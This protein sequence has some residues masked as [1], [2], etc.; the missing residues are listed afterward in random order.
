MKRRVLGIVLALILATVGTLALVAYVKSAKKDASKN[1]EQVKVYVVTKDIRLGATVSE[2]KQQITLTD[3]PK[4]LE[5]TG[6]VT[7]LTQLKDTL[8]AGVRLKAG[9]QLLSSRL[10]DPLTLV[11]VAVPNG[12]QEMT[13]ALSP[14]RA[15]G[16]ALSPGDTVGIVISY[17]SGSISSTGP[18]TE[19]TT[20]L[21][22]GADTTSS[23]TPR[24]LSTTHLTLQKIL[25]TAVQLSQQD[26]QRASK[27]NVAAPSGAGPADTIA[28]NVNEAPSGQ[29]LITLAVSGPQVEQIVF[30]AEFGHIWL[31]LEGANADEGGTRIL[32][33]DQ[34]YVTVGKR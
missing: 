3:V 23:T 10:V 12:L 13:V 26:S 19:S 2:I 30:A 20:T 15:V 17:D 16:A 11:R 8:V 33:L 14:E 25:V 34:A 28:A 29:L 22:G 4:R 32:T 21:A 1:E 24:S 18:T 6:A 5:V 31:T 9:E 7:D 27:I